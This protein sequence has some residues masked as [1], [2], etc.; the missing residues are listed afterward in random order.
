MWTAALCVL[1]PLPLF[2]PGYDWGRSL[3]IYATLAS[4]A[5][6]H[7]RRHAD[8]VAETASGVRPG[9]LFALAQ[10]LFWRLH[11]AAGAEPGL[12]WALLRIAA[13]TVADRLESG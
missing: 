8:P 13:R 4:I 12:L 5:L 9:Q 2:L 6:L 11:H 7:A 1:T 10:P 3:H